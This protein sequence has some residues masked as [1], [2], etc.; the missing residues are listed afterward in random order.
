MQDL[1][2]AID[3]ILQDTSS[4]TELR[5]RTL[6]LAI[7]LVSSINQGSI[8]AYLL[9]RDLFSTLTK[10]ISDPSTT[11]F[12]F[13]ST[14]LLGLLSNFRKLEA[15][16][17]Y[18][19]RIED[20]VDD[21]VMRQIADVVIGITVQSTRSYRVIVDDRPSSFVASLTSLVWSSLELLRGGFS[22]SLPPALSDAS[23]NS[24]KSSQDK[25]KGKEVDA[26]VGQSDEKGTNGQDDEES[27]T[28]PSKVNG[29]LPATPSKSPPVLPEKAHSPSSSTKRAV[30][31]EENAFKTMP[32]EMAV[33]LL[34]FYD[35]LNSNKAFCTV[36]FSETENGRM[37]FVHLP[38]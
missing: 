6:Q 13:E 7:V 15:R 23:G 35:L 9:R 21:L 38:S 11:P 28:P 8:N 25:G 24:T 1:V 18:L 32:P 33:I 26:G 12:T 4:R 10:F 14:L 3:I 36:V 30:M 34:P 29:D 22:L 20:F 5:H 16:N 17:P 37:S 27:I 2:S 19:A 31:K